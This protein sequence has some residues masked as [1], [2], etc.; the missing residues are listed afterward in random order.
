G[1]STL[2]RLLFRFY[3]LCDG[4]IMVDGTDIRDLTQLSLRKQ[5]GVVPQDTVLFNDTI[6]HNIQYG[7]PEA[8]E[9]QINQAIEFAQLSSFIEKLPNGWDTKVG[10]RGLKVSGGEKQRIAIARVVLKN[11]QILI[12]DE[13]TSSLDSKAERAISDALSN[14]AKN[15]TTLVIAHRLSTVVDAD[16]ILVLEDGTI[17]EQGSHQELLQKNG[18]YSQ[19]WEMQKAKS[20]S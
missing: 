19:L 15:H 2:A 16:R 3:D 13:A 10:E 14:V 1:K 6:F 12:F 8:N 9:Q 18:A 20:D 4:Q 7:A 11:P 5:I 17:V